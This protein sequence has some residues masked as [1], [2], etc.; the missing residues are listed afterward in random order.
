MPDW[1]EDEV[2]DARRDVAALL[3]AS[4]AGKQGDIDVILDGAGGRGTRCIAETLLAMTAETIPRWTLAVSLIEDDRTRSVAATTDADVIL[5]EPELRA[6][7]EAN[8]ERVQGDII[9]EG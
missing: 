4:I 3:R 5:A 2:R 6:A 7:V 8:I 1:R 9:G